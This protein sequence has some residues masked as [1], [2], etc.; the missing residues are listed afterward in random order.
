[1]TQ[2]KYAPRIRLNQEEHDLIL[3]R[4]ENNLTGNRILNIGDLH[5]PFLLEDYLDFCFNI[6]NKYQ[7][8]KVIF[9]GDIVDNHASSFWETD[10][11]GLGAGDELDRAKET[12]QLW[13]D[14]FPNSMVCVGNHD[15][16]PSRKAVTSGLPKQWIR[17]LSEVLSTP[18][19]EYAEEF[20]V[21]DVMYCHGTAKKA[22]MRARSEL[23]SVSQGHYHSE[24][25]IEHFVGL[26]RH[27]WAMQVGCGIDRKSYAMT[28]SRHF[29][30]PQINVGVV[31]EDGTLPILEYM[32]L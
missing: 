9:T 1:M 20:Y 23:I 31:L 18:T 6:Y 21:D 13:H 16:I 10:P 4:R 11:N 8:N 30:K 24:S 2:D 29:P 15:L 19:W 26:N 14:T 25:Y 7:C 22:R 12:V 28:Y 5:A 32:K 27:I 3:K 17:T